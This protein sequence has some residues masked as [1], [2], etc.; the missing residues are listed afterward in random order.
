LLVLLLAVRPVVKSLTRRNDEADDSDEPLPFT[1]RSRARAIQAN[2][3]EPDRES[4]SAQIE[5][6]QRIVREQ[7]DDALQALRRMLSEPAQIE[8]HAR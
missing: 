2:A 7:P 4:L 5:L 8:G 6:A 3:D 1:P